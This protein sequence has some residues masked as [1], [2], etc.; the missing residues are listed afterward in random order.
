[1]SS[2]VSSHDLSLLSWNILAP[3]WILKEWYP[4]MYDL[5]ADNRTRLEL[6]ISHIKTLAHDIVFI[7]E[8]QED[9]LDLFKEKLSNDYYYEYIS[10]NPTPCSAANGLLTLIRKNYLYASEI[11]I[12]NGILDLQRGEAIQIITIPS[13]NLYLL[14][15]HLDYNHRLDQSKMIFERCKTL[16]GEEHS[17]ALMAGDINA[18]IQDQIEFQWTGFDHVFHESSKHAKI[19]T[20]YSDPQYIWP[21]MVIDHILYDTNQLELMEHGKAWDTHD[22]T[23]E[24]SLKK[25]GSDHIYIWAT[26]R[27]R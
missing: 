9:Q 25:F 13:K 6:V 15:I 5:A 23:L 3:C 17:I 27:F 26:F 18:E 24:E 2:V 22:R 20:Y 21:N 1:M 7:Q 4:S 14:N 11:K 10:N 19:P 8:A 12:T 16:I